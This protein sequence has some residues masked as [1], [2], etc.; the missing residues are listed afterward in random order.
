MHQYLLVAHDGDAPNALEK[1]MEVR[2]RHF[3][4]ARKMFAEGK[5]LV[6][7][8]QLTDKGKMKGSAV[9][10]QFDDES[11]L[12]EYLKNEPYILENVW[13][14]YTITPIRVADLS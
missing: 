2:P 5:I 4:Y 13:E 12:E 7:G 8:A 6:G 14:S 11:G 9:I 3:E 10:L 1:R